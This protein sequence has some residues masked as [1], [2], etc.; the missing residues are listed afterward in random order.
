MRYPKFLTESGEIRLVAPSYGCTS[1]P[2]ITRLDSAEKK[3][4]DMGYEI[5]EAPHVRLCEDFGRSGP[6]EALG[7]ELTEAFLDEGC[8]AVLSVGGGETMCETVPH[9]DFEAIGKAAPKWYMGFSDNTN[10]TFLSATLADTAAIYGPCFG[11]FGF[12][13]PDE[14]TADALEL[15]HGRKLAF[16][17]YPMWEKCGLETEDPLA[18]LNLTEKTEYAALNYSGGRIRGRLLG[19]CGD[20]LFTLLGTRFDRV[21]EFNERYKDDGTL[22][23]IEFC[24]HHPMDVR[25]ALWAMREA[26]WF[27]TATGFIIGRPVHIDEVQQ[28]LDMHTAVEGAIGRLGVP[29]IFDADLGHLPPAMPVITGAVGEAELSGGVFTLSHTLI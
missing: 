20:I 19:G 12:T 26:G 10:Y 11:S 5:V 27:D 2:Y 25:R 23:F 14:G 9:I 13:P 3:F 6:E 17:G 7:K 15:I 16:S 21:R 8:A 4:R 1:E 29:I 18:P 22:W 28:G 24:D